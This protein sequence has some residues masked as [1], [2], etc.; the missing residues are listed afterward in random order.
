MAA[1]LWRCGEGEAQADAGSRPYGGTRAD[2][3][4]RPYVEGEN[5]GVWARTRRY[6]EDR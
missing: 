6:D 5:V 1:D 4:I 2:V 3:G